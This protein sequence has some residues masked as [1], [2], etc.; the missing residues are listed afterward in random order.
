MLCLG[1]QNDAFYCT[2]G[3]CLPQ[4]TVRDQIRDCLGGEDELEPDTRLG[5]D[6][7][8]I[9]LKTDLTVEEV[10]KG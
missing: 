8:E 3:V 4:Y 1:C 6:V 10:E 9:H 5:P 2:S 7:T